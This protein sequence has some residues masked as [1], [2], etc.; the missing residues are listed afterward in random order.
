MIRMMKN[1]TM[2]ALLIS[3]FLLS[4]CDMID[5]HPY[6]VRIKGE[7]DVNAHNIERIEANCKGKTTLRFAVIGH[8]LGLYTQ[9]SVKA[10]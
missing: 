3:L 5:Y 10:H 7:T 9:I 2:Y 6:D 4:G 8:L 1:K